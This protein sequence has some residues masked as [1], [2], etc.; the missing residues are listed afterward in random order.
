MISFDSPRL[1]GRFGNHLFQYAFLRTTA[2]RLGT[3]FYCPP[4]LGDKIF[5][6]DDN[7]E[8]ADDDGNFKTEYRERRS[9]KRFDK[10]SL[11]IKDG[12]KIHGFFQSEDYFDRDQV[13]KWY[14]FDESIIS[15]VK[16]KY[17]YIDFSDSIGIHLRLGDK[18]SKIKYIVPS[19]KYYR[20]ALE[21]INDTKN[22][23]VFSDE[24]SSAKDFFGDTGKNYIYINDNKDYE[25]FYLMT[26][27]KNF[28]CSASTFS[29]WGAYLINTPDK[30]IVAPREWVRPGHLFEKPGLHCED[31]IILKTC[32]FLIDDYR[33]LVRI[34]DSKRIINDLKTKNIKENISNLYNSA[35]NRILK[36]EQSI[37]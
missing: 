26:R 24:T 32:R 28:I 12:T 37:K 9:G 10:L 17:N 2:Q 5:L 1:L 18:I 4:W 11:N 14:T 34:N 22:I 33:L 30:I 29:W 6:L 21:H 16:N 36:D 31:W 20:K 25:D 13:L 8:R 3:K 23:L 35:K 7:A 27:C 15:D 19:I